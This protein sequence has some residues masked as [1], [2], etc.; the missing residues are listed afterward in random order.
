MVALQRHLQPVVLGSIFIHFGAR[1]IHLLPGRRRDRFLRV[2]PRDVVIIII[3]ILVVPLLG[4]L[5]IC[6]YGHR[7]EP[8]RNLGFPAHCLAAFRGSRAA[9]VFHQRHALLAKS[10]L[11]AA[12]VLPLKCF[13]P[14]PRHG[15]PK[16]Q[17]S[18]LAQRPVATA[19]T[20][21]KTLRG[22]QPL[23]SAEQLRHRTMGT[24]NAGRP[25]RARPTSHRGPLALFCPSQQQHQT[26]DATGSPRRLLSRGLPL[27]A[28]SS[29][30][31]RTGS[32]AS[33]LRVSGGRANLAT[34]FLPWCVPAAGPFSL[35][36]LPVVSQ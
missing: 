25:Q 31:K 30:G 34:A 11:C 22:R 1:L 6:R 9:A 21:P 16:G 2:V 15:V 36:F 12:G 17:G 26:A 20:S 18:T 14:G 23:R 4:L 13:P 3:F 24:A 19:C 33:E 5:L 8:S 7:S 27:R 35:P 28:G 32:P 10:H 29:F